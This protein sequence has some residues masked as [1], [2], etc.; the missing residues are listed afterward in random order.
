MAWVQ[1]GA[2]VWHEV[3]GHGVIKKVASGNRVKVE[4]AAAPAL[5]RTVAVQEL[6][7]A[8]GARRSPRAGSDKRVARRPLSAREAA[9]VVEA[10]RL[11][12]VPAIGA[13]HYTVGREGT[14]AFLDAALVERGGLRV[15]EGAFGVGKSHLL[16]V[17]AQ[18][19]REEGYL[20]A[21]VALDPQEIGLQHPRR[22]Y[23]ALLAGLRYPGDEQRQ[24]LAPLLE[25][26]VG[27]K[28]HAHPEG[29]AVSRFF[30]PVLWAWEKGDP[31]Q[32]EL[33]HRY[34]RGE[35]VDL[36]AV[37]HAFERELRYPGERVFALSDYRTYSRCYL[38]LLGTVAAWAR[39]AGWSGLA[40][41]FDEAERFDLLTR[42]DREFGLQWLRYMAAA[43]LPQKRLAF[44]PETLYRGG[45]AGLKQIPL[46]FRQRQPLV[47]VFALT[48]F[49]ETNAAL[50]ATLKGREEVQV[51]GAPR[52]EARR[53]LL[54]C[55]EE[56]HAR[57]HGE[58][59]ADPASRARM[60]ERILLTAKAEEW[61]L[62]ALVQEAVAALDI[63]R[64]GALPS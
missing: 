4:F 50:D 21:Q 48:P 47:A 44:R 40:L 43:T 57:A 13:D 61:P 12:V 41:F 39:D 6:R 14:L 1:P 23:H 62:R 3:H 45:H 7:S 9:Q 27:S 42:E 22:M 60:Q 18:R 49:T 37:R 33:A 25:R 59:S 2:P 11:G 29:K 15:L 32:R 16:E 26:L 34:I 55:I 10:L 38:H 31:D 63:E 56:V 5:P 35:D 36:G 54:S 30:T 64:W 17:G 51:L 28:A 52:P 19:A 8:S 24:G 58:A 53:M 20:T 46:R